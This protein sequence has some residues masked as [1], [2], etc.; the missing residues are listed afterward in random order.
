[1]V[2]KAASPYRLTAATPALLT[3]QQRG[4]TRR[5]LM[6][7]AERMLGDLGIEG[8]S[9]HA[10]ARAAGQANKYAVQY[11]FVDKAGLIREILG[12]RLAAIELRRGALMAQADR[13]GALGDLRTLVEAMFLPLVEQVD[14]D[15]RRSFAR[16]LLQF[17]TQFTAWDNIAHP[18]LGA[19]EDAASLKLFT[20][21][22]KTLPTLSAAR[23][24]WRIQLQVRVILNA[25]VEYE[26]Q[27][28]RK[29][30]KLSLDEIV[31]DAFEMMTAALRA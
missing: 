31:A 27:V 15:G 28:L 13:A 3:D 1:M 24:R 30:M 12:S 17:H 14:D 21:I 23:L 29:G 16:F 18:I 10:I 9:L 22:G 25:L 6:A 26:N 11:H 19:R 8:A 2:G 20:L 7:T 4:A 5:A